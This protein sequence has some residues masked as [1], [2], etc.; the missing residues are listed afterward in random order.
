MVMPGRKYQQ[1]TSSYRYSI[2]GQEKESELNDNITTAMF[3]EYDSRTGRRWNVDPITKYFE[4][5]YAT[6][7]C[8]PI[9]MV[10]PLGLDP[11]DPKPKVTTLS[12]F[13][14]IAKITKHQQKKRDAIRKRM[15]D[16]HITWG[17]ARGDLDFNGKPY[18]YS[19]IKPIIN[20]ISDNSMEK[21][22]RRISNN[23]KINILKGA[24]LAEGSAVILLTGC[25]L[26]EPAIELVTVGSIR[27]YININLALNSA[28]RKA[29]TVL[30]D[31]AIAK[32]GKDA[33][34]KKELWALSYEI[35]NYK[36]L[37]S[38]KTIVTIVKQLDKILQSHRFF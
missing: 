14:V 1:G 11:E 23:M 25:E 31:L 24:A 37:F 32:Y 5:P 22:I 17:E 30:L 36:E 15:K 13:I 28:S 12:P 38:A 10:D 20:H 9:L 2:N 33:I 16:E 6:F 3:W 29:L 8:N 4:S 21:D 26:W 34:Y 27:A 19:P 35:N 7:G 18:K